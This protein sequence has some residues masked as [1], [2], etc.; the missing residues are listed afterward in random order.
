MVATQSILWCAARPTVLYL[1]KEMTLAT[2]GS[3]AAQTPPRLKTYIDIDEHRE[4]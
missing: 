1:L 4:R 3:S 2:E